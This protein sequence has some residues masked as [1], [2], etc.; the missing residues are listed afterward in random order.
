MQIAVRSE[1]VDWESIAK[2]YQRYAEKL[3]RDFH[4]VAVD[5]EAMYGDNPAKKY[6]HNRIMAM[7]LE[8]RKDMGKGG[9]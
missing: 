6:F 9:E 7:L 5:V 3:Q 4:Q 8:I 1:Y 2:D